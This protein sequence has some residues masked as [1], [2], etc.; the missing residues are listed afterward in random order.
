MPS[1]LC[2]WPVN[3]TSMSCDSI[4]CM[5]GVANMS[6]FVTINLLFSHHASH[7]ILAV[8]YMKVQSVM[9]HF[10][11]VVKVRY[12]GE[13]DIVHTLLLTTLVT[14]Q[15][16]RQRFARVINKCTVTFWCGSQCIFSHTNHIT[17]QF[18]S[19]SFGHF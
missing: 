12:V 13:V 14:L 18:I 15:K 8:H 3:Q 2:L 9:F 10:H 16:N 1:G 4:H 5:C 19:D 17:N 7:N 11:K 6:Y